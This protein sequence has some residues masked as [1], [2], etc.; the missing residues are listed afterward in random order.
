M[1]VGFVSQKGGVGKSSLAR[2]FGVLLTQAGWKVRIADLDEQQETVLQ[3][4]RD[5]AEAGI[6]PAVDVRLYESCRAALGDSGD[7]DILLIDGPARATKDTHGI[8]GVSHLIVQPSSGTKDDTKPAAALYTVLEEAGIPKAKMVIALSRITAVTE[9]R[10]GRAFFAAHGYRVLEGA[11]YTRRSY[12]SAQNEGLTILETIY[13]SLN[14]HTAQLLDDLMGA[15]TE[16]LEAK[17]GPSPKKSKT[18]RK[19]KKTASAA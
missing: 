14:R 12:Q 9:E 1:I 6:E 17:A 16:Q 18:P 19:T 5:R 4:S 8:A 10:E 15:V 7:V 11:I 13:D 2:A 3:W